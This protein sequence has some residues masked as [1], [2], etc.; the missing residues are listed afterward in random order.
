[1][2]VIRKADKYIIAFVQKNI[3]TIL[4]AAATVVSVVIRYAN[5]DYVSG[6]YVNFLKPWFLT[7]KANG[8]LRSLGYSIGNY[9][10]SYM[11]LFSLLTYLPF[12]PIV[13][14][15]T[16]SI[17]FDYAGAFT[18][19]L[20]VNKL[21]GGV[22]RAKI[23]AG[24]TYIIVLFLPTVILNS[25]AWAQCDFLYTTFILLCLYYL[26]NYS[27]TAAFVLYSIAF[28]FKLQAIFFLPVLIILYFTERK[29]SITKFLWI[30]FILFCSTLPALLMG[31][32]I[33]D[34]LNIYWGQTSFDYQINVDYPSVYYLMAENY[35]FFK[36]P[37]VLFAM[38]VLGLT[39]FL[40]IYWRLQIRGGNLI[41]FTVLIVMLC[42]VFLPC[43]H[44]RYA[45][46]ADVLSV[47]YFI[48]KR[49]KIYVPITINLLSLL[50]YDTFIFGTSIV[51]FEVLSLVNVA[52]VAILFM[53][54]FADLKKDS[55]KRKEQSIPVLDAKDCALRISDGTDES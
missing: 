33:K 36:I 53:D 17:L 1:M 7:V 14:I 23:W 10:I 43:M 19:G 50:S 54:V 20:L 9:N 38:V 45:F 39:A 21:L 51:P 27:Y 55:R 18:A 12:E 22:R 26:L 35:K 25:S 6:D 46:I 30:P 47:V 29:F 42:V 40:V 37:G 2:I 52:L 48:V 13:S 34:V 11:V 31:R 24:I 4:L 8:G 44:E 28:C 32:P 15:K 5:I 3:F 41:S 16:L 49:K